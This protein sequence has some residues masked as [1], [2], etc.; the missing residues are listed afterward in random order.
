MAVVGNAQRREEHDA[1]HSADVRLVGVRKS[2]GE[3]VAVDGV[4]VEVRPGEF[5]TM[6]GPSASREG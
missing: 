1:A 4:D 6:L 5:F 2:Y 3:V